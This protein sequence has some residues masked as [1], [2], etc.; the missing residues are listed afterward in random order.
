MKLPPIRMIPIPEAQRQNSANWFAEWELEKRLDSLDADARPEGISAADRSAFS[1][2]AAASPME[3]PFP[4]PGHI[5]LLSHKQAPRA[6]DP[7]YVAVI[8]RW[9][10]GMLLVA[11]FSGYQS[12]ATRGELSTGRPESQLAVLCPWCA[13]SVSPFLLAQSWYIGKLSSA[14]MKSAWGVFRHAAT[15]APIPK[16]IEARVGAPIVHPLDPRIR[17][18]RNL[19]GVMATLINQTA[20][21]EDIVAPP[22]AMIPVEFTAVSQK[23]AAAAE[24]NKNA[25]PHKCYYQVMG[26]GL[27]L[28]VML[29]PDGRKWELGV[30]GAGN[31]LSAKLD[32]AIIVAGQ[33][34]SGPF[35]NG[36][37]D[38]AKRALRQGFRIRKP[39]GNYV[40]L[41]EKS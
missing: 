13:C 38:I 3:D 6:V 15:G 27:T 37:A 29:H 39:D 10:S 1:W 35:K 14:M 22:A 41:R 31:T 34:M 7:L 26:M 40:Q 16:N 17:Y 11:P 24:V 4:K 25:P 32:G 28:R 9:E 33:T 19:S 8:S 20:A 2:R 36:Q 30:F 12:P 18:Q 21:L 5:R 23:V